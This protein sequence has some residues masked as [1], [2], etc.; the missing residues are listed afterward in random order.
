MNHFEPRNEVLERQKVA[1][2]YKG[3]HFFHALPPK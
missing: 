2:N 3:G 1:G